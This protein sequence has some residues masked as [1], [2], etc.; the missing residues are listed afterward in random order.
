MN[1]FLSFSLLRM[2][3]AFLEYNS[4]EAEKLLVGLSILSISRL[5]ACTVAVA[6]YF[7]EQET[8]GLHRQK[9][10]ADNVRASRNLAICQNVKQNCQFVELQKPLALQISAMSID[11]RDQNEAVLETEKI[12]KID[13]YSARRQMNY[14]FVESD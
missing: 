14:I 6:Q 8:K 9:L 5:D 7:V 10:Y 11:E 3:L 4:D 2:Y 12:A 1:L 13:E